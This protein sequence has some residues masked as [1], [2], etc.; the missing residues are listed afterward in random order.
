MEI[1]LLIIVFVGLFALG[2]PI[3]VCIALSTL[4]TMVMTMDFM[5]AV[6]T[7][8]QRMAGGLNSFALLLSLIHI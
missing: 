3:A 5:P 4:S 2:V 6:T 7:I 1:A 8:A